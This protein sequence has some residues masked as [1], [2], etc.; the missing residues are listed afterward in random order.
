M[1]A[2]CTFTAATVIRSRENNLYKVGIGRQSSFL[3]NIVGVGTSRATYS[4]ESSDE[5]WYKT[6]VNKK[7]KHRY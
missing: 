2:W 3:S 1:D 7:K 6:S 5:L 4:V